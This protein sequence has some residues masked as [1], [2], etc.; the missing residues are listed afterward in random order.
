MHRPM[1]YNAHST[2]NLLHL[3]FSRNLRTSFFVAAPLLCLAAAATLLWLNYTGLP[4]SWRLAMEAELSKKG[5]EASISKL[6]YVL[7]GD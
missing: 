6:R 4:Q 2:V 5:I 3:K 1:R 7:S